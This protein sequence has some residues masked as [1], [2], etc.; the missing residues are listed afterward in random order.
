MRGVDWT[1]H[2]EAPTWPTTDADEWSRQRLPNFFVIG[3]PKCGTTS[4][5][6]HLSTHPEIFM[7][8]VKEPAFFL[9]DDAYVRGPR[10]YA[11]DYYADAST[12][13]ARGDAT[14][15]YVYQEYVAERLQASIPASGHRFVVLARE[16]VQR[17]YSSYLHLRRLGFMTGDFEHALDAQATDRMELWGGTLIEAS[18]YAT[19][20]QPWLDR[21][22]RDAFHFVLSETLADETAATVRGVCEFLGVES[23]IDVDES[24]VENQALE[25]RF[26]LAARL[27]S[28]P[29]PIR[30]AVNWLVP[31]EVTQ[32]I[33][34]RLDRWDTRPSAP[35]P[36]SRSLWED[37]HRRFADQIDGFEDLTG[38]DC[39]RWREPPGEG[40]PA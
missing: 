24:R 31:F 25:P 19:T 7:P 21:F 22:G 14:P 3:F 18:S 37:V 13:S 4:L 28:L 26:G 39:S 6:A 10:A 33:Q 12:F 27:M 15:T 20:L 36:L 2:G 38:L 17:A 30:S 16:P 9:F 11:A 23:S 1:R 32:R 35:Q 8:K 5:A 29:R 40:P 34:Q